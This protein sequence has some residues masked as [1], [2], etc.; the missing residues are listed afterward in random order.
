MAATMG[1]QIQA[2]ELEQIVDKI[3]R[4]FVLRVAINGAVSLLWPRTGA[5]FLSK[6]E[7]DVDCSGVTLA[8]LEA[9]NR[10]V[11]ERLNIRAASSGVRTSASERFPRSFS[12]LTSERDN[13]RVGFLEL[14]LPDDG[15]SYYKLA[16]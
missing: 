3:G 2:Y 13:G 7:K 8:M 14:G 15:S 10:A 12:V 5:F 11:S 1:E 16:Q 4:G 6:D 9:H